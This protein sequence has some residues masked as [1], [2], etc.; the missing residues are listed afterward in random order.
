LEQSTIT[1]KETQVVEAY[2][3]T[4]ISKLENEV[5]LLIE[6]NKKLSDILKNL[7]APTQVTNT[8]YI[9][10]SM[11][12]S[13]KI[14]KTGYQTTTTTT[15]TTGYTQPVQQYQ[16][17][18]IQTS[19]IQKVD[20]SQAIAKAQAEAQAR[21]QSQADA[22]T[23]VRNLQTSTVVNSENQVRT[24]YG[25]RTLAS[26]STDKRG[27]TSNYQITNKSYAP[28]VSVTGIRSDSSAK[29]PAKL[30]GQSYSTQVVTETKNF[31]A[32]NIPMHTVYS[33]SYNNALPLDSY[34]VSTG[35]KSQ[36]QTFVGEPQ[37]KTS[38]TQISTTQTTKEGQVT[39][40]SSSQGLGLGFGQGSQG[41]QITTYQTS[42]GL[43]T[44]IVEPTKIVTSNRIVQSQNRGGLFE[45]VRSGNWTE[46][47]KT[48]E[49]TTTTT[50]QYKT[51]SNYSNNP[52][53][54]S[55]VEKKY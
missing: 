36:T 15:T 55:Y 53:L 17:G 16:T 33:S 10:R 46:A 31:T 13:S 38:T 11:D 14:N 8:A 54:S 20:N 9:Q 29:Q 6:K 43:G 23:S 32:E 41:A 4:E 35:R 24:S 18:L 48:S 21:L 30:E 47:P 3:Q 40:G 51:T 12:D 2:S 39:Y 26:T 28:I 22:Q 49:N 37:V 44:K 1:T 25:T 19:T 45:Q 5:R 7:D 34:P 52:Y 27:N 50:T 42:T